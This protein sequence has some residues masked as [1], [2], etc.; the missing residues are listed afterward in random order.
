[1]CIFWH[2]GCSGTCTFWLGDISA[3]WRSCHRNVAALWSF[4]M[5]IFQHHGH[6]SRSQCHKIPIHGAIISM[7]PKHLSYKMPLCQNAMVPKEVCNRGVACSLL[8][9]GSLEKTIIAS[10][11]H[12]GLHSGTIFCGKIGVICHIRERQ[13]MSFF[14]QKKDQKILWCQIDFLIICNFFWFNLF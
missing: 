13:D 1:M 6:S 7:C 2:C 4:G 9:L 10:L 5:E 12:S 8:K 14:W 11:F 3:P